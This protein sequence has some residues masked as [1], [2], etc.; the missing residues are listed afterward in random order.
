MRSPASPLPRL[1]VVDST[2]SAQ[3]VQ[4]SCGSSARTQHGDQRRR[5]LRPQRAVPFL[6]QRRSTNN[7]VY[8]TAPGQG[9]NSGCRPTSPCRFQ[10]VARA[11]RSGIG[12]RRIHDTGVYLGWNPWRISQAESAAKST[13]PVV[14]KAA[15]IRD[16]RNRPESPQNTSASKPTTRGHS[17][18]QHRR[19]KHQ[20]GGGRSTRATTRRRE[21]VAVG[22]ATSVST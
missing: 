8:C 6:R 21:W 19:F 5:L 16:E 11:I 20:R 22:Q 18:A 15:R 2:L 4:G 13:G 12:R 9:A 10:Q 14:F 17:P 7:D 3:S 1:L